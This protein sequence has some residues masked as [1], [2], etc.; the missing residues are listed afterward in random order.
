M[1]KKEYINEKFYVRWEDHKKEMNQLKNV[2][3]MYEENIRKLKQNAKIQKSLVNDLK[4]KLKEL[5][6]LC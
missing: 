1:I 4:R 5:R 3:L 6:K 2:I